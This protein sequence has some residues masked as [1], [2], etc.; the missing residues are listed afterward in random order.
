[1]AVTILESPHT[2]CLADGRAF[3]KISTNNQFS[4][5]GVNM[6]FTITFAS[7]P[8]NDADMEFNW[9]AGNQSLPFIFKTTPDD[10][11]LQLPITGASVQAFVDDTLIPALRQN[12]LFH[13]TFTVAGITDGVEITARET[14]AIYN[15]STYSFTAGITYTQSTAGVDAVERPNFKLIALLDITHNSN[16]YQYKL[17]A[18]PYNNAVYLH[19]NKILTGFY[20]R[21]AKPAFPPASHA[22]VS[23]ALIAYQVSLG[24]EFGDPVMEQKISFQALKYAL[25][26]GAGKSTRA[27]GGLQ[28]LLGNDYFLTH[29]RS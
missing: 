12:A 6:V 8:G 15:I 5:A 10:S 16:S 25:P 19:L 29:N 17:T 18:Y 28:T 26:G 7:I 2:H 9:D 20:N 13:Q 14:G 1:M 3:F 27:Q 21:L 23:A 24:E 4:T 11:G 22:D